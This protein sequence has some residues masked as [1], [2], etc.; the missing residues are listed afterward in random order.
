MDELVGNE[1]NSLSI[2]QF[3]RWRRHQAGGI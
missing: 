1:L 3:M 2:G